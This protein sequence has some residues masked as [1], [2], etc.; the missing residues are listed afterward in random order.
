MDMLQYV[1]DSQDNE[2]AEQNGLRP[3]V[4]IAAIQLGIPKKML[5]VVVPDEEG[6]SQ[7]FALANARIV[8]E[9]VQLSYLKNGEGCLSVEKEHQGLV[10]R[11]ARITVKAYDLLQDKEITIKASD[12][13]AI[14]LQ[15]EIDHFSGTLFYDR[16]NQNDPCMPKKTA[17][18]SNNARQTSIFLCSSQMIHA[19]IKMHAQIAF[20]F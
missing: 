4:G 10:P 13:L 11:H 9:S 15:H 2:L 6:N 16:I 7:E 14:V 3:A 12:Y 17:S 19:Y 8:S 5:A 1:R 20:I 18:S